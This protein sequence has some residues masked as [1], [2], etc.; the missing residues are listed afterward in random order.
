MRK[1]IGPIAIALIGVTIGIAIVGVISVNLIYRIETFVRTVRESRMVEKINDVE[2]VKKAMQQAVPYSFYEASFSV[3]KFGGFCKYN[4]PNSCREDC[5]IPKE[6]PSLECIPWWRTYDKIYSPDLESKNINIFLSYL[7][8]RTSKIY[9]EYAASMPISTPKYCPQPPGNVKVEELNGWF[10]INAS[11]ED[12]GSTMSLVGEFFEIT[13]SANFTDNV[14]I[15]TTEIYRFG[16]ERF[17]D[18]DGIKTAFVEAEE[19]MPNACC[20]LTKSECEGETN[21]CR[22]IFYG[23]LCESEVLNCDTGLEKHCFKKAS[24]E[25][26]LDKDGIINADEKYSCTAQEKIRKLEEQKS[27][28]KVKIN[29]DHIRVLH[30]SFKSYTNFVE[31]ACECGCRDVCEKGEGCTDHN[32]PPGNCGYW[33]CPRDAEIN[34]ET[35]C[36]KCYGTFS[37]ETEECQDGYWNTNYWEWKC[38]TNECGINCCEDVYGKYENVRCSYKYFGA[39]NATID[40]WD[41]NSRYP[42]YGAWQKLHLYF[43][44]ASG[45]RNLVEVGTDNKCKLL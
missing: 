37:K 40:V 18:N 30:E 11:S 1:G 39:A 19:E 12:K 28:L 7:S 3:L 38:N 43:R 22:E 29:L 25:C 32:C 26:D 16:K 21:C 41:D 42:I 23:D 6:V 9:D 10:Q 17:V 20:D 33:E 27:D 2:F 4:D 45:T 8:N 34:N 44:V 35:H 14:R 5:K 24:S 31:D 13:D 36:W 15:S